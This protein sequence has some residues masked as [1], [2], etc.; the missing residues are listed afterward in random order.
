[1]SR[2]REVYDF[3]LEHD[4]VQKQLDFANAVSISRPVISQLLLGRREL[5]PKHVRNICRAFPFVNK[6]WLLNGEGDMLA[7]VPSQNTSNDNEPHGSASLERGS[8]ETSYLELYNTLNE[9]KTLE[10]K[11]LYRQISDLCNII[12]EKEEEISSLR[13]SI[14]EKDGFILFMRQ[15]IVTEN[16]KLNENKGS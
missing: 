8:A 14:A 9:S 6:N 5:L 15:Q 3:L 16:Q 4:L 2:L 10:V 12:I 11:R 13:A 7:S 1:M